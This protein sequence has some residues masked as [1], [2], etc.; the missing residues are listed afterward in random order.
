MEEK[1]VGMDRDNAQI[2]IVRPTKTLRTLTLEK[3][4]EAIHN[5][6]FQPGE[7]LVERDLCEQLGVSR[8]IVR[9]VLRHLET[10]GLVAILPNRGPIVAETTPEQAQQI[11]EIRGLLEAM[12]ARACAEKAS[13]ETADALDAI[14]AGIRRSYETGDLA[15][16][17]TETSRFYRLLFEAAGRDIAYGIVDSLTVRINYL[18]SMTIKTATRRV[19]GPKQMGRI[20]E[21]I[22]RGDSEAAARAAAEHVRGAAA[23]AQKILTESQG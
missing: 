21:A 22:R 20:V 1:A 2:R 9:E 18:R 7:R 15:T 3:M 19:E 10:E 11:Y 13:P 4:R 12:A 17:L 6:Y 14:L 23:M 8:T 5:L 16:V